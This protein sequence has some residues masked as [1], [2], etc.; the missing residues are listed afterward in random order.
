[1]RDQE[2]EGELEKFCA[3]ARGR[4]ARAVLLFGSRARGQHTEHSDADVC[5]IADDLPE[6]PFQRRYPAPSGY[7]SLAVFGFHPGEFLRLLRQGNPFVLEIVHGGKL[8]YDDG[9]FGQVRESFEEAIRSYNL[10]RTESGWNWSRHQAR[11]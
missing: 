8:L 11:P 6:D 9:F 1:M 10:Q 4:R 3:E 2:V 7:R 5:L